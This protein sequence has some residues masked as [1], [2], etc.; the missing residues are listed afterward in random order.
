MVLRSLA[1]RDVVTLWVESVF[2]LDRNEGLAVFARVSSSVNY[3]FSVSLAEWAL[4][5]FYS[6]LFFVILRL[7]TSRVECSSLPHSLLLLSPCGFSY[8]SGL[9]SLLL[10]Y[11]GVNPLVS[12]VTLMYSFQLTQTSASMTVLICVVCLRFCF[13]HYST[14]CLPDGLQYFCHGP[15]LFSCSAH[16]E[17]LLSPITS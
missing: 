3:S 5:V 12:I 4:V 11:S 8:Q 1:L 6:A 14:L 15:F 9:F 2:I 10:P 16:G 7:G 17:V 13:P